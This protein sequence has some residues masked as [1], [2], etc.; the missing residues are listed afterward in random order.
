M[1]D[2]TILYPLAFLLFI[3]RIVMMQK[4]WELA[5]LLTILVVGTALAL[6]EGES[7]AA[8]LAGIMIFNGIVTTFRSNQN[9]AFLILALLFMVP[10]YVFST[11]I[12]QSM[13]LGF[14]SGAYFFSKH[15][16]R[17]GGNVEKRRDVIQIVFGIVLIGIF[18]TFPQIYANFLL[19]LLILLAAVLGN[20]AIR[21]MKS[22]MSGVL[23]WFERSD[24]ALG[25]GAMW[26]AIGML[27][28]TSFLSGGHVIAVIAAIMIGDAVATLVGM[29]YRI[30][31]PYNKRKS[32]LGT[33]AYFLSATLFSF[34]FIG[35]ISI[36]TSLVAALSESSPK[37]IDDNFDTSVVLVTMIKILSYAGIV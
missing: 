36:L 6:Y 14:L 35:Y 21:N 8:M 7:V 27:A 37:Q 26:L 17:R 22:T 1:L 23:H 34:P 25:Q 30:A 11:L 16:I 4:K 12:A 10:I 3:R 13:F 2:Y 20:Y 24:A 31:L 5:F 32:I 19:E 9:Y 18:V 15:N 33:L 28:A 29:T